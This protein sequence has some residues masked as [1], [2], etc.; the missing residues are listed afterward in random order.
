[1]SEKGLIQAQ[2]TAEYLRSKLADKR[3]S[4]WASDRERAILTAKQFSDDIFIHPE[5]TEIPIQALS[6]LC[7]D[8]FVTMRN[9][10]ME[11]YSHKRT[12]VLVIYGH[13]LWFS[14]F[15]AYIVAGKFISNPT[16]ELPN[17]SISNLYV[18]N[19]NHIAVYQLGKIDHLHKIKAGYRTILT[20]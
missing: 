2:L 15:I 18:E 16:I 10:I 5:L 7:E 4:V 9:R 14:L 19:D 1:L 11:E 6:Q 17:C 3:V 8:T 12:D 20:P 13:S